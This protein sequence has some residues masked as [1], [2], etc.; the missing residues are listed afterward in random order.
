[1]GLSPQANT[2]LVEEPEARFEAGAPTVDS[3]SEREAG[4]R[5]QSKQILQHLRFVADHVAQHVRAD[6]RD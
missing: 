1:M 5:A 2:I 6:T 3:K 4:A